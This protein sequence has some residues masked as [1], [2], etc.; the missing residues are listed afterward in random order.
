MAEIF[1]KP[2]EVYNA[3]TDAVV[4]SLAKSWLAI[5]VNK[6]ATTSK[7]VADPA[8]TATLNQTNGQKI[9]AEMPNIDR[10]DYKRLWSVRIED[11]FMPLSQTFSLRAKKRLNVSSLVDGIDIIQQTHKEAKTIECSLRLTLRDNQPNLEIQQFDKDSLVDN[12]PANQTGVVATGAKAAIETFSKFLQDFYEN[13][14][15]FEI[16]NEMINE[17][18]GVNHVIITDYRFLPRTGSGTFT[19]EFSLTEVIYGDNVLTFDAREL[20]NAII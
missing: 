10:Y 12:R 2:R 13:D 18:F 20:V 1:A 4:L 8:T 17:T 15:V 7:P 16:K 9:T 6:P 3:T 11:Y 5:G 19:F 14:R